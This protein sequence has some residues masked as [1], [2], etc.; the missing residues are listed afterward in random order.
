MNGPDATQFHDPNPQRLRKL[1][2]ERGLTIAEAA[3]LCGVGLRTLE[4]YLSPNALQRNDWMPYPL[5][6]TLEALCLRLRKKER[7]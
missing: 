6:F 2:D 1:M 4:R 5:Q 3:R 7:P